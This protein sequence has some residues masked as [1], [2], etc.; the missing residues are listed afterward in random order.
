MRNLDEGVLAL[1]IMLGVT[2][3]L[4][5]GLFFS[6]DFD[7][8]AGRESMSALLGAIVGGGIAAVIQLY[9]SFR[10][11]IQ[12]ERAVSQAVIIKLLQITTNLYHMRN[13][14]RDRIAAADAAGESYKFNY[15][16]PYSSDIEGVSLTPEEKSILIEWNDAAL[17]TEIL[18]IDWMYNSDCEAMNQYRRMHNDVRS[19]PRVVSMDGL[20]AR[21][22]MTPDEYLRFAPKAAE[23]DD[24]LI[25]LNE[26]CKNSYLDSKR[27][28]IDFVRK[29]EIRFRIRFELKVPDEQE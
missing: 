23:L 20:L 12:T 14:L 10:Q 16:Q 9:F 28:L 22:E 13:H 3:A 25:Q 17:F 21:T 8:I 6:A 1:G 24:L 26:S 15:V 11:K 18:H 19:I 4:V 5:T 29:F 27:A 7:A 2:G